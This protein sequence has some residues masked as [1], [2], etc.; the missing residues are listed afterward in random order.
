MNPPSCAEVLIIEHDPKFSLPP[1]YTL[2]YAILRQTD[3]W[4][5]GLDC[6]VQPFRSTHTSYPGRGRV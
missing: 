4:V 5:P 6:M 1:V 3:V 2:Q